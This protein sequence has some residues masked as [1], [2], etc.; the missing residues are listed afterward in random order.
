MSLP[1]PPRIHRSPIEI[2]PETLLIQSTN[3]EGHA[4]IFVNVNSGVRG[5]E[6]Y[7]KGQSS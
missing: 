3:G 7:L 6:P 2:A 1:T 5:A 4:P